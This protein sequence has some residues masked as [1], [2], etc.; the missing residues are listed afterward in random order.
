MFG[1]VLLSSSL[2][3]AN[4]Q[5]DELKYTSDDVV[6]GWNM[7]D[8]KPNKEIK[9]KKGSVKPE[10]IS[11]KATTNDVNDALMAILYELRETRKELKQ[12]KQYINPNAPH[13][14]TKKDGTKCLA[15]SDKDCFE[16][17][18]IQEGRNIPALANL[19]KE[20]TVEN[21][22]KWLGV[23]GKLFNR[24][25]AMGVA[26]KFAALNGGAE[27]YPV[28]QTNSM[29]SAT[30]NNSTREKNLIKKKLQK[31]KDN[32]GTI[33]FLGETPVLEK[34]WGYESL[35]RMVYPDKSLFNLLLVFKTQGSM[36]IYTDFYKKLKNKELS[37]IYFSA[38]KIVNPKLFKEYSVKVS[39][40]VVAVYKDDKKG[41]F[42]KNT[43]AKG[44]PTK[45]EIWY[46]YKEFLIYN[47]ILKEKDFY[48]DNIWREAK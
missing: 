48:G 38:K 27:V 45:S 22:E 3:L 20:P 21:A 42:F 15:N 14:I 19:M 17:P 36:D 5:Q 41:I 24:A 37:S 6:S 43:I 2:L 30:A 47:K 33:V 12:I 4:Q 18:I 46:G 8:Y 28:S 9:L 13:Y 23:Q 16:M 1:L 31:Y 34:S 40:T 7:Y 44:F 11:K 39:P 29:Y 32:I 26:I 10:K 35:S 25:N